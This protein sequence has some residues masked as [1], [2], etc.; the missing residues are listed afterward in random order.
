MTTPTRIYIV[1]DKVVGSE[2]LVRAAS[3]AQAVSRVVRSQF[4]AEFASQDDIVRMLSAGAKVLEPEADPLIA[5]LTAGVT[6]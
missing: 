1:T 3:Q 2:Q 6:Q 5:G 4:E